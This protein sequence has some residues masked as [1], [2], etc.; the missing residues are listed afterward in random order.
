MS[1]AVRSLMLFCLTLSV[2]LGCGAPEEVTVGLEDGEFD[3]GLSAGKG[4]GTSFSD[5]ELSEILDFVNASDAQGLKDAGV[6]TR[7]ANNIGAVRAGLDGQ[8]GTADDVTFTT[9]QELDDVSWVGPAAFRQLAAAIDAQC[10]TG[11]AEASV[12]FS[13]QP[14]ENSHIA[15]VIELIDR[16]QNRI[17][18]AMYSFSDS[19]VSKALDRATA[20]GVRVRMV[21]ETARKDKSDPANTKS[22]KLEDIGVDVRYINKIMH[23]KY[24]IFDGP[25]ASNPGRAGSATLITGSANWSN[26]AATRYDE[27]TIVLRGNAEALTRFQIEFDLMWNNSRDFVWNTSLIFEEAD[28]LTE[29]DIPSDPTFDAVFTSDNFDT[30]V[31]SHGNTFTI[32]SGRNTVSDKLV[33]MIDEATESIHVASGHLRSRPVAEA[34]MAKQAANPDMDIRV[35]LDSQEYVSDFYH[36]SQEKEL[37]NCLEEATTESKIQKCMDRGFLFGRAL[38]LAGVN[39]R[40]KYYAYR[41][42]YSYSPQM[43][44]KW[45]IFDRRILAT[46]SYNLSDNAEHNTLENVAIYDAGVGG[47]FGP[48]VDAFETQ[49][50]TLWETH[51]HDSTYDD[52]IEEIETATD[53]FPIVFEAMSLDWDEVTKLKAVI[54]ANC[55]K[56]NSESYRKSP[57]NHTF[58]QL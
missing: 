34:L 8:I 36:K 37:A 30:K 3:A 50:E 51:M 16:A 44:N 7:A 23:H 54:K 14:K 40:Y 20:R 48:L 15:K 43:H 12:I 13:P 28:S 35:Y 57:E 22:S 49:F 24:A 33:Q 39:T 21:F 53:S 46:G 55:P 58:C 52:L 32:V 6:H 2:A 19:G 47:S 17:D 41:W 18:I 25:S 29:A 31:T 1:A 5:C 11:Q 26:S 38:D 42:H 27:N 45:L 10:A 56:I 9:I 4:D